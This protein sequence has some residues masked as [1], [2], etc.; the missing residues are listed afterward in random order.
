EFERG[1]GTS[2]EL[3]RLVRR[4]QEESDVL[5]FEA[6]GVAELVRA[7]ARLAGNKEKITAELGRLADMIRESSFWAKNEGAGKVRGRHVRKALDEKV[8]R[9]NLIATQLREMITQGSILIS[10]DGEAIG[11]INGLSV[12]HLGDYMFGRPSRITASI[13]IGSAGLLNIERE[14]RLSGKTFD[15]AMLILDGYM[16]NKYATNHPLALS[17]SLAMEQSYG[18][19][20]GDSASIAELVCLLSALARV[21]LRQGIAV[22]GSVNQWGQVQAVGGVSEKVEGFYDVCKE[23]GLTGS[24]GVCLPSA[25]IRNLVLR[26]DVVEAVEN[27]RFHVWAMDSVDQALKLLANTPAGDIDK[28]GSIHWRVDR[29]LQDMIH[30]L[31]EQKVLE[32]G[33][34]VHMTELVHNG[35]PDPRP[36]L[37]GRDEIRRN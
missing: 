3:G 9:S 17:A 28:E 19:I 25:N 20:E 30:V 1:E 6:E 23:L 29:R 24:Q 36:P 37:P 7:G 5:P 4:L 34:E 11:Q 31:K 2:E 26:H 33:R 13:G 8:F 27:G 10:V 15:K 14:S 35:R 18:M 12:A 22:T 21:P 32:H 16:R